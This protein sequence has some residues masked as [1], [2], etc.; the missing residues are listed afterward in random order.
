MTGRHTFQL[1]C[2]LVTTFHDSTGFSPYFL[3]FGRHPRLAVDAFLGLTPDAL[4]STSKTEYLRI[5]KERLGFAYIKAAEEA[6]RSAAVHKQHYDAKARNSVLKPG[7]LVLIKNFGIRGKH[8]IGGQWEQEPYVV[9]DQ[10]NNDKPVYEVRRQN[11]RSRKTR[12]LHRILLLPF[13][14]L[15]RIEEEKEEEEE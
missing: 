15:P 8:K 13:M 10:P 5:L 1:S 12:L 14:C 4:L 2:T 6:Y 3:M 11:T 9:I 7:D